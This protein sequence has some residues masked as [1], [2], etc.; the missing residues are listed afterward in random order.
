MH[1]SGTTK[2]IRSDWIIFLKN[3]HVTN[4]SVDDLLHKNLFLHELCLIVDIAFDLFQIP[5][6]QFT[7][8]YSIIFPY[9]SD[10]LECQ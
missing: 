2:V 1:G 3:T 4:E 6:H 10:K 7:V 5:G 8:T 9:T